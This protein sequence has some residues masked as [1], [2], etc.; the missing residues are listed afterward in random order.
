MRGSEWNKWN[1][2]VHTKGTNKNDLFTSNTMDEFF[3]LF[4]K[5]AL[6]QNISAIA[7]TDY[8]SIDNYRLAKEYIQQLENK[9]NETGDRLFT[10]DEI[11]KLRSIF[12]F[13]NV[14]LRMMPSTDAGKLI[15]IHCLFNPDYVPDLENDFF[16]TIENQDKKKMNRVGIISYGKSLLVGPNSEEAFYKKGL[17]N[18]VVDLKVLKDIL[19]SN[20]NLRNNTIVV[21]SN[22]NKDGNS[23]V[24]KHYDLFEGEAGALD[25]VRKTIYEISNAIFSANKK[26]IAYF[27]GKRLDSKPDITEQE[28][29]AERTLVLRERGSFKACFVGCDAHNELNLF[30]RFTWVKGKLNF[31]GFRQVMFEPEQRVKIQDHRPDQKDEK[32]VIDQ[33]RFISSNNLFTPKPICFNSNLNVIIGGKSSGKSILLYNIAKTLL[34]DRSI[35]QGSEG[36]YRYAFPSDFDFEV[37]IGSGHSQSI[38][39]LDNIPSILPAIKYIPQNYL[40]KLAEPENKKGNEL[41]KLVRGLLLE[42]ET[43]SEKYETFLARLKSN[44]LKRELAI[45]AYFE[46]KEKIQVQKKELIQKGDTTVLNST[47]STNQ[48][49]IIRLKENAGLTGQ[50]IEEYNKLSHESSETEFNLKKLR[51]DY[52]KIVTFN[53]DMTTILDDLVQRRNLL[54]SSLEDTN[55]KQHYTR[56]YEA[57]DSLLSAIKVINNDLSLNDQNQFNND[58]IFSQRTVPLVQR[59]EE[60]K[61][62]LQP[63]IEN[64]QIKE[65][66]EVLEKTVNEDLQKLVAIRQMVSEITDNELALKEEKSRVLKGYKENFEEYNKLISDLAD[67]TR[68]LENDRLQII[69][70]PRFNFSKFRGKLLNLIDGRKADWSKYPML[71]DKNNGTTDFTIEQILQNLTSIFESMVEKSDFPFVSKVDVKSAVKNLLFDYFFDYWDVVYDNDMLK[72]MSTGKASFVILMLI[73][74]LS[75]S[76]API[77]IDQPEDNLDNRS[78]SKDLIEYLRNKKLERQI[79]LVTHNANVV[80]N[81]DAENVIVGNQKGQNDKVTTS[82]YQF[83]Y[84]NGPIEH[85]APANKE[86]TDLLKSMGI[87]EHIADVVEG[88][89]EAFKKRERKYGFA[90]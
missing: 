60:I 11:L 5:K 33:V 67:R 26:D 21:V 89:E 39:R 70:K 52:T 2:H 4:F 30:T 58:N 87:R 28:K 36:G 40:S 55:V 72:D 37:T 62:Q 63:F 68:L 19:D 66:I 34:P 20:I 75:K 54:I 14:E 22:S 35:L 29:I 8:F 76:K 90:K 71:N 10:D 1:I 57:I 45:N 51:N 50:Q 82:L 74:G 13:P 18:Y 47:V 16:G 56:D 24:Q 15:N 83:D 69:G 80:V 9:L 42:D 84:I 3:C 79:I 44:D 31:N 17:D 78:I 85:T 77:L 49:K 53:A 25:G 7:I 48:A 12:F 61:E 23:A 41:I 73:V 32:L 46:L 86:E 81:A 65:E 43:Y 59:Q 88:G 38:K 64:L 6:E 27:L